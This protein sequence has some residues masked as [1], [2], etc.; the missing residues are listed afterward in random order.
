MLFSESTSR[1]SFDIN[2]SRAVSIAL[3]AITKILALIDPVVLAAERG[4]YWMYSISAT[5]RMSPPR[6]I[7]CATVFG[8]S[9]TCSRFNASFKVT[10]G[11]YL[12][13]IGQI[14]IQLVLP[15]QA[16]RPL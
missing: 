10:V 15:A 12:A 9:F 2:S 7:L 4:L 8:I 5:L 6:T 13:W 16:R 1:L 3:P 11:S 14:G